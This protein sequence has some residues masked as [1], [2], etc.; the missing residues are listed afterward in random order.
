[1]KTLIDLGRVS[2]ETKGTPQGVYNDPNAGA[3]SKYNP[4]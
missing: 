3:F 1:M 2:E 4:T